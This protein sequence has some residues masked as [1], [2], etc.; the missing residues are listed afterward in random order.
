MINIGNMAG[1]TFLNLFL[2]GLVEGPGT[3][4]LHVAM[5]Q[6]HREK[7]Q[8]KTNYGGVYSLFDPIL[9]M[10]LCVVFIL[11]L[12]TKFVFPFQTT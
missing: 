1:N 8:C 9:C 3:L 2:L 4:L 6:L 5:Q 7:C 11:M 12:D 10:L